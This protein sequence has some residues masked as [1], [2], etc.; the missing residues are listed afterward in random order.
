MEIRG[1]EAED[2]DAIRAVADQSFR[3]SYSLSP[4]QIDTIVAGDFS[5]ES[6]AARLEGDGLVLVATSEG[7]VVGFADAEFGERAVLRWLHVD[8]G[9]RGE[10]TGT[11]LFE[12]ARVEAADRGLPLLARVLTE[13]DEGGGFC[14]RFDF[15]RHGR[16]RLDLGDD[17]FFEFVYAAP[18][19]EGLGPADAPVDVPETVTADGTELR[20]D[21]GDEVP[22]TEGP[23]FPTYRG[24]ERY[25]YFCTSCGS[26][27]VETDTLGRLEC[28]HCGNKHLADTW[29]AAYLS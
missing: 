22:G 16:S 5:D 8:P 26:T 3:A 23:F 4:E 6:L 11:R 2:G 10:E 25:G 7:E 9:S 21:R 19:A 29:D 24:E 27:A 13:D 12:R 1:A 17:T 18:D 28:Q 20:V 14:E 15:R